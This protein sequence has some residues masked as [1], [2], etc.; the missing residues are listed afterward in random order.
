MLTLNLDM[1]KILNKK[2]KR[3]L[4]I[5]C[6]RHRTRVGAFPIEIIQHFILSILKKLINNLKLYSHVSFEN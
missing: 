3:C 5:R 4:L 2:K 6:C 1:I